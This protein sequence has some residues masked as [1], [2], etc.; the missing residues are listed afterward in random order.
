VRAITGGAGVDIVYEHVGGDVLERSLD[1]LRT[2]GRLLTCGGHGGEV[3]KLD[4]I[5]FFRRELT[6]IGSNS[7]TQADISKVL[8][9]VSDGRLQP[10]IA[11]TF[12]LA[13]AADALRMLRE[14]R[15]YGRVLLTPAGEAA[16]GEAEQ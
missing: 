12:P 3:A 16:A 6:I 11:A 10:V 13:A 8:S 15:N 1:C 5:P 14:R 4:I 2:G 9:L 7:A